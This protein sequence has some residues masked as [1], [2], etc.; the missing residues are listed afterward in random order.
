MTP[1]PVVVAAL[2][3]ALPVTASAKTPD[4]LT[5]AVETLCDQFE[6][7]A[8]G[9]CNSYC[10]ARDCDDP[11]KHAADQSCA[12]TERQFK[13]LTGRDLFCSMPEQ[14]TIIAEDDFPPSGN[15]D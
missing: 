13:D 11:R 2:V 4:G 14:C 9:L 12:V 5:P 1:R 15:P 7:R 3:I 8:F 6:G 10:E